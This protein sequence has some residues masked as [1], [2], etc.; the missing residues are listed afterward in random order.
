M[1]R[2]SSTACLAVRGFAELRVHDHAVG[3]RHRAGGLQLR[4]ALDLDEAHAA[5]ADG[6]P[7]ARLVA[8]DRDLDAGL[9][10]RR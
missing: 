5:R 7:E 8:E 4:H 6:G 3:D 10:R 2:N 9:R 1:S